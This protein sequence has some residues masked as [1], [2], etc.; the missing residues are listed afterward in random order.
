MELYS[1]ELFFPTHENYEH[2]AM[3][4]KTSG[5]IPKWMAE[6]AENDKLSHNFKINDE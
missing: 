1:G 2:L 3:I 6:K 4:E 5:M